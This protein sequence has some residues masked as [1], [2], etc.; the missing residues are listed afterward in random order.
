MKMVT[1]VAASVGMWLVAS[2]VLEDETR[3]ADRGRLCG[4]GAVV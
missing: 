4:A 3:L 1:M 2:P